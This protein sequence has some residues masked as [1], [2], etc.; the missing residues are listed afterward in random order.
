MFQAAPDDELQG[1][2]A[3]KDGPRKARDTERRDGD[4]YYQKYQT[5]KAKRDLDDLLCDCDSLNAF[6]TLL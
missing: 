2:I 5:R 3:V 1:S 6:T 4:C